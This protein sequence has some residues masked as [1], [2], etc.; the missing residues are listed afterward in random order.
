MPRRPMP[1]GTAVLVI[2][3]LMALLL[4]GLGVASLADGRTLV[5]LLLL[6]LAA[7]HVAFTVV[8]YRRRRQWRA[9]V[10]ARRPGGPD[11]LLVD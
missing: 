7:T 3:S 11:H 1:R 4:A 2:R 5:G 9:R 8:R 6:G 10:Q